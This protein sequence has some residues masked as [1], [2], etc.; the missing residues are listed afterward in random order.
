[1]TPTAWETAVSMHL[2][3]DDI[4]IRG[5]RIGVESVLYE[6]IHRARTPKQL[7]RAY[8][9]LSLEQVYATLLLYERERERLDEYLA[10]YLRHYEEAR[11]RF[12]ADGPPLACGTCARGPRR[13]PRKPRP[14]PPGE[15]LSPLRA[16]PLLLARPHRQ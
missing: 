7:A 11:D 14:R 16:S 15:R 9:T 12:W 13:L 1:M 6:A 2:S 4:R 3:D 10:D 8:R 5:T